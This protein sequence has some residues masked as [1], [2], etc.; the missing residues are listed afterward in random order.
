[1][2]K[3]LSTIIIIS[4]V[5]ILCGIG[6]F[7]FYG[8]ITASELEV[9]ELKRDVQSLDIR[10]DQLKSKPVERVDD[11]QIAKLNDY[12]VESD[13]ALHFIEYIENLATASGLTYRINLFDADQNA[14]AAKND[15]ETLKTSLTTTGS[16]TDTRNFVSLIETLPYNVRISKFDFKK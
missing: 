2:K 7:M 16:L 4:I 3:H 15:K 14:E 5:C 9:K 1:M 10:A 8:R 6:T 12:F 13:G 11:A